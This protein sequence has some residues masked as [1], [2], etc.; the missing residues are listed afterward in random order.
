MD[1]QRCEDTLPKGRRGMQ[2]FWAVLFL[3][4]CAHSAPT[5]TPA[6]A[7]QLPLPSP[8]PPVESVVGVESCDLYLAEMTR[9]SDHLDPMARVPMLE[10][11]ATMKQAW[12][13]VS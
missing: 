4:S 8:R 2:R 1:G 7:P 5:M 11:L 6:G 13:G 9:C 3:G 10:S 12:L